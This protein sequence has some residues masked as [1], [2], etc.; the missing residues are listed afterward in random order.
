MIIYLKIKNKKSNC[1]NNTNFKLFFGELDN[2]ETLDADMIRHGDG[3]FYPKK[4]TV[5]EGGGGES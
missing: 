1:S 2:E 4:I 5:P 3:A